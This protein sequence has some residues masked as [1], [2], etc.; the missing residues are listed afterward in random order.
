MTA[1]RRSY[2][3]TNKRRTPAVMIAD[4]LGMQ[5]RLAGLYTLDTL[6]PP[7]ARK[8]DVVAHLLAE[9]RLT[10]ETVV[11]VGDSGDDADAAAANDLGFIAATYGYGNPLADPAVRPAAV[12][13]RLAALPDIL[14]RLD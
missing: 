2:I 14:A 7:A 11:M 6:T 5:P 10:R 3:V 13:D 1:G 9:H 4:L 12:L 8:R